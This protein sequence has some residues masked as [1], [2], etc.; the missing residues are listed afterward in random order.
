MEVNRLD[1]SGKTSWRAT[2]DM[3]YLLC[4][5]QADLSYDYRDVNG[6]KLP[7]VDFRLDDPAEIVLPRCRTEDVDMIDK[8]QTCEVVLGDE[9]PEGL[10]RETVFLMQ[11]NSAAASIYRAFKMSL[12]VLCELSLPAEFL[13]SSVLLP[14]LCSDLGILL[15]REKLCWEWGSIHTI[16]LHNELDESVKAAMK[17]VYGCG[18]LRI[19]NMTTANTWVAGHVEEALLIDTI[20]RNV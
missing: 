7:C 17:H 16:W 10:C 1:Q 4:N 12:S 14:P 2:L 13:W 15:M 6:W 19:Q 20:K 11:A 8:W 3:I 5:E 9:V 18:E